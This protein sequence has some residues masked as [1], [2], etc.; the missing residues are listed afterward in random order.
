MKKLVVSSEFNHH[1]TVAF[2]DLSFIYLCTRVLYTLVKLQQPV[3]VMRTAPPSP[4][5]PKI[6]EFFRF[7]APFFPSNPCNL[8]PSGRAR[9]ITQS[10]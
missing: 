7:P 4:L 10:N 2:S 3:D 8:S 1:H 5:H 9:G 6:C